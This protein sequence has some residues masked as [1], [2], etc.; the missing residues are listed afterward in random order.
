[1]NIDANLRAYLDGPTPADG[2]TPDARYASFDYCFNYFQA[3]RDSGNTATIANPDNIQ[4]SCLQLGF[5]LASWGMLRGSSELLQRSARHL[6]LIL[7]A[8]ASMAP[9]LWEID[10]DTYTEANI[11]RLLEQAAILRR[12][13]GG[14]SDTLVTKVMLGVFGS[15]PAFDTN[16]GAGLKRVLG[17]ARFG[18]EA[19][20]RIAAFYRQ[21]SE[22]LDRYR[23]PTLEF[24]SGKPT[25]RLY[26]RAKVIDMAFFSEGMTDALGG[27][28]EVRRRSRESSQAGVPWATERAPAMRT[29]ALGHQGFDV[30]GP[31]RVVD[32]IKRRFA[33][34]GPSARVPL[35][36]GGHFTAEIT[37]EGIR[38]D[39]L[40]KQPVLPWAVFE[41]TVALLS[42][43]GG[44]A[45]R[46]DAMNHKLGE[47]ELS[48]D[49]V[50][51]HI[52]ATVY[53][54]RRGESVFRRV[55]PVACILIW[56][57]ICRHSR[58]ELVLLG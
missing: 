19:L 13:N 35:I 36:K 39:N 20:R 15:V 22:L 56:A 44:R 43:N 57:G 3:F 49:S 4:M 25:E 40:D 14:M 58:G 45:S 10:A 42:R 54:Q 11:E 37:D 24:V 27:S 17:V 29:T 5:Y 6:T 50:E 34:E 53:G 18:P 28:G 2:R 48:V 51:G 1:M 55:T 23:V 16:V 38:V 46:G 41:E 52:A 33:V 7:Q 47:D 8:I 21:N 32:T 9:R 26:S 12:A 30:V 31:T